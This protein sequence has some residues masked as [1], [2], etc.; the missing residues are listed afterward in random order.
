[1]RAPSAFALS[2]ACMVGSLIGIPAA[3][4]PP[5]VDDSL[6]SRLV[7]GAANLPPMQAL[8]QISRQLFPDRGPYVPWTYQLPPAPIPHTPA[9]GVCPSGSDQCIDDT[10]ADMEARAKIMTRDCDDN[11]PLLLSY[12]HTTKGEREIARE[13]GGFAYPEHVNDWSTTYAHHYFDAIDNYY[14]N[15]RPDL[16]P[17]SWKQN[18]RASDD[19]SLTVFGNVAVAYN[20][21]ITHDLP[22][23]IAD[24]GVTAP[25][26]HSYK[27]DHEKIDELLAEA[28]Q[29]T[30]SELATRYGDADPA[31]RAPYEM[32]PL[33][34][35][36][37]GQ[38]IQIW[39]EY[40]WRG[41]EQLLLAPN[42]E[43]RAA[44]EQQIDNLSNLLGDI[45]LKLFARTDPGPHKSHC[46]A[47]GG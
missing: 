45:I 33:T 36:A 37:F 22:I 25:D 13:R 43:A 7:L 40:A 38:V 32:E 6:G 30:V 31:M 47:A 12:L 11:A 41:A 21:H 8:L 3:A 19:H 35:V 42:Q 20:A 39:R 34:G 2:V 27:P 24:M 28:E 15:G 44:I 4:E 46:P 23:V 14:V 17:E 18:F 26:G 29:G 10:I 9:H 1:M 5:Q 16:V